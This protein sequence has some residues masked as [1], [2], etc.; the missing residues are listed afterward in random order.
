[1]SPRTLGVVGTLVWD[2]IVGRDGCVDVEDWGG[3]AYALSALSA[4]LAEGWSILPIVKVGSD[5]IGRARVFLDDIPRVDLSGIVEVPEPNNRV[6]IRYETSSRRSERLTGGVPPWA[7]DE[8]ATA[9]RRCDALYVNFIS[10]F[11]LDLDVA[12]MLERGFGGPTY[13]DLHSLFLDKDEHGLRIP[14]ALESAAEWLRCFDVVQLNED[15]LE[16]LAEADDPWRRAADAL[17]AKPKLIAVTLGERGAAYVSVNGLGPD[18][19]SWSDESRG[20]APRRVP[21][22]PVRVTTEP[23]QGDPTGCGDVWGAAMFARLLAGDPI[24]RAVAEGN[25]LGG[26]NVDR[27]GAR[28][29][30]RYLA[31]APAHHHS[32][33]RD[34]REAG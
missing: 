7:W 8:L 34:V 28:E 3:I 14:S 24:A 10:G 9:V 29:L 1:M 17:G 23:H 18:P 6:E 30:A 22:G 21:A 5:V 2:R 31:Q 16:L 4:S 33:A 19:T 32:R 25:R 12:R 20:D 27:R 15:E 26:L 11:E 13:A